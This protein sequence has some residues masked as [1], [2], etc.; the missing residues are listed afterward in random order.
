MSA[1]ALKEPL[2]A[3]RC[4][5]GPLK[6]FPLSQM[7]HLARHSSPSL[8]APAHSPDPSH[9]P[10]GVVAT[11]G[12]PLS[13]KGVLLVRRLQVGLAA[14][15]R[16]ARRTFAP[17]GRR[18][19]PL[20]AGCRRAPV[21]ALGKQPDPAFRPLSASDPFCPQAALGGSAP[22]A[23]HCPCALWRSLHCPS[24]VGCAQRGYGAPAAILAVQG[25]PGTTCWLVAP[26]RAPDARLR[27][28]TRAY[29][30]RVCLPSSTLR[31]C[32][33]QAHPTLRSLAFS[34]HCVPDSPCKRAYMPASLAPARSFLGSSGRCLR[35]RSST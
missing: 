33:G 9:T 21:A 22:L 5:S 34:Q 2:R 13:G 19:Q 16:R 23:A 25:A 29:S 12:S 11:P 1:P 6:G 27:R 17:L 26:S 28:S 20:L 7:S 10:R 4:S 18:F 30:C 24:T 8:R 15:C 31:F 35:C 3:L 14:L 32:R